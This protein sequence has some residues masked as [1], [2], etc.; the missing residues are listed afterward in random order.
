M[1][2]NIPKAYYR[3]YSASEGL[4]SEYLYRSD[5]GCE[6][7]Y[8]IRH[9]IPNKP[10]AKSFRFEDLR[11]RKMDPAPSMESASPFNAW[12]VYTCVSVHN[13]GWV[14]AAEGEKC[15]LSLIG[16]GLEDSVDLK[17]Y[18]SNWTRCAHMLAG[19]NVLIFPDSDEDGRKE[20]DQFASVV[21]PFTKS[22]HIFN[23]DA[24][25]VPYGKGRGG[26]IADIIASPQLTR[27]AFYSALSNPAARTEWTKPPVSATPRRFRKSARVIALS[28]SERARR[29]FLRD[30]ETN[31]PTG[32]G[33]RH[34]DL[35]RICA[36]IEACGIKDAD[37]MR[38]LVSEYLA[39]CGAS[40][41]GRELA[42]IVQWV[43]R[44]SQH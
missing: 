4:P 35:K 25:G 41:E 17:A 32:E 26:D 39:K 40:V 44:K 31:G 34:N 14:Y 28:P 15:V 7:F 19:A 2:I 8:R 29:A 23:L 36:K 24:F 1:Q 10:G 38:S 22:V 30:I 9:S 6:R 27:E 33:R 16:A 3:G 13:G 37:E 11:G 42:G 18:G 5:D 20:A 43:L 21:S 12:Q